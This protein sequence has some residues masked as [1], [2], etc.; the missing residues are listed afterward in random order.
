MIRWLKLAEG[1]SPF[2]VRAER[3][4]F[5]ELFFEVFGAFQTADRAT[6]VIKGEKLA[7]TGASANFVAEARFPGLGRLVER[8]K[9]II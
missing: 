8:E 9:Q 7:K 3:T 5:E 2:E 1:R 6:E 4:I